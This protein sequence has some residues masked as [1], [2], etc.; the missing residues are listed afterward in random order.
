MSREDGLSLVELLVVLGLLS[1]V[2]ASILGVATTT[3]RAERTAEDLA[4]NLDETRIAVER[5]RDEVRGADGVC[6]GSDGQSMTV[7]TDRNANGAVDPGEVVTFALVEVDG[8]MLLQREDD[9]GTRR[10]AGRLVHHGEEPDERAFT[11]FGP[12][13]TD[14]DGK[15]DCS[16]GTAPGNS[17]VTIVDLFFEVEGD[18]V[19]TSG[20][21]SVETTIVLRNAGALGGGSGVDERDPSVSILEPADG[22][23]LDPEEETSVRA[24]VNASEGVHSVTF[25]VRDPSTESFGSETALTLGLDDSYT[26]SWIP[27]EEDFDT[28]GRATIRV[29]AVDV[30]GQSDEQ[31][32][33]VIWSEEP[34]ITIN[35]PSGSGTVDSPVT[36]GGSVSGPDEGVEEIIIEADDGSDSDPLSTDTPYDE[37]SWSVTWSL[38]PG[39]YTIIAR[40]SGRDVVSNTVSVTVAPSDE[41]EPQDVPLNLAVAASVSNP[42]VNWNATLTY[43]VTE[44]G[45]A[46]PVEDVE[47][48][49]TTEGAER[50]SDS[51]TTDDDGKCSI[52]F[53]E[54]SHFGRSDADFLTVTVE[55]ALLDGYSFD[56]GDDDSPTLQTTVNRG[57]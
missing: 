7:W 42:G 57:D 22:Q 5:V 9:E 24:A 6:Q 23:R 25:A 40:I 14:P 45:S 28:E 50:R 30:I 12:G 39:T 55:E 2:G 35:Q 10:L 46:T 53:P 4:R 47:I 49:V 33:E 15:L 52:R 44:E 1:I 43:T 41:D 31:L 37:G 56:A 54:K 36:V 51:C 17:G 3:L 19:D 32:V 27:Q 21:L 11:Y 34:T 26:A 8:E 18:G 48:R 16:E 29:T 38:E 20:S 13:R